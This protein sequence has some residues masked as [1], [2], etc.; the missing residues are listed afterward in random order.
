MER[1]VID[2]GT[3][4]RASQLHGRLHHP[5]SVDQALTRRISL[6]GRPRR[7]TRGSSASCTTRRWPCWW[8]LG[9][10]R[11]CDFDG[12]GAKPH[13]FDGGVTPLP[14][15][16]SSTCNPQD[17]IRRLRQSTIASHSSNGHFVTPL[18]QLVR[19]PASMVGKVQAFFDSSHLS[20]CTTCPYA[21]PNR[22]KIL[23]SAS[24]LGFAQGIFYP[25]HI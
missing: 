5:R 1:L 22:V 3:S 21:N 25:F 15:S 19:L 16:P 12:S 17:G 18:S 24:N 9:G 7:N 13:Q 20:N 6:L 2:D 23:S 14:H 8:R 10:R 11:V 4:E